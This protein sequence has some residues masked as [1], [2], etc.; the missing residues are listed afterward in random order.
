MDFPY[1][2]VVAGDDKGR[3]FPVHP[4]SGHLLGRHAD[5][6][7]RLHD[8]KLSRFHCMINSAGDEVTIVNQGGPGGT[9]VNGTPVSSRALQHGDAIQVGDTVIRFVTRPMTEEELARG[10]AGP[11]EYDPAELDRLAELAGQEFSHYR[12]EAVLARGAA[13]VV[14]RATDVNDGRTVALKVLQPAF[15]R[16]EDD[17]QRFIRAM[18]AVMPLAHPNLVRVYTAGQTGAHLWFAME[19]VEGASLAAVLKRIG[20]AGMPDWRYSYRVGLLIGRALAC[21]YD[22]G[23]V[24]RNVSPAGILIRSADKEAKLGGWMLAKV[25]E[26]VSQPT[27]R[28]RELLGDVNYM[29]PERT[30]D[31]TVPVDHRS[32]LFSLG[33]TCYALLT[34]HPPFEADSAT[35]TVSRIRAEDPIPPRAVQP[36]IPPRFE[37]VL[38]RLLAKHPSDRYHTAEELVEELEQIGRSAGLIKA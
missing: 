38:L 19:L 12:V 22:R 7:Y 35:E 3:A 28:T 14:F 2:Y 30:A 1:F 4:G 36:G 20:S 17:R 9:L 26:G 34:G 31:G 37:A 29:S 13:G 27:G 25:W 8:H 16:H 33:A 6:S 24:H 32:D 21:T 18:K 23:I 15:A 10:V 5:A 11:T